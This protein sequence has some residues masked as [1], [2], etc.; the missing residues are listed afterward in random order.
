MKA[1]VESAGGKVLSKQPPFRKIME[2]KHNKVLDA[3]RFPSLQ[4]LQTSRECRAACHDVWWLYHSSTHTR[5]Q[6][7]TCV[8]VCG[9][10]CGWVWVCLDGGQL[11][12]FNVVSCFFVASFFSGSWLFFFF[13]QNLPEIILIS[14]ENDLHL[15]R[16]YFLKNIGKWKSHP[17]Q[18]I[19]KC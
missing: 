5:A 12:Y 3:R 19:G 18:M 14:C 13:S 10:S 8:C 16:E 4:L 9:C 2:H 17:L 15:C 6:N 7:H 1:I 11:C